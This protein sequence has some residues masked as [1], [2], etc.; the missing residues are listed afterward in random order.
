MF[1]FFKT[2]NVHCMHNYSLETSVKYFKV[3]VECCHPFSAL[4]ISNSTERIIIFSHYI[5]YHF[6]IYIYHIS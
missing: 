2:T 6:P 3:K 5:E 1:Y 4:T